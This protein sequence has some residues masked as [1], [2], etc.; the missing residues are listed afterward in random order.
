MSGE[1]DLVDFDDA[2]GGGAGGALDGDDSLVGIHA[3]DLGLV[4]VWRADAGGLAIGGRG[5]AE[6]SQPGVGTPWA[7]ISTGQCGASDDIQRQVGRG[8]LHG[9]VVGVHAAAAGEHGRA[10]LDAEQASHVRGRGHLIH[11]DVG[12]RGQPEAAQFPVERASRLPGFADVAALPGDGLAADDGQLAKLPPNS[13][14][15]ASG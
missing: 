10:F 6:V 8:Q 12:A 13:P 3:Q 11:V 5:V 2:P 1:D 4:A 14:A 15:P 9:G 7:R